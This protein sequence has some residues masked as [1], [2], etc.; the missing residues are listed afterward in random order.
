MKAK[1]TSLYLFLV[2]ISVCISTP[3]IADPP[4]PYAVA[5]YI[6]SS[7]TIQASLGTLFLV[8][9]TNI[10]QFVQDETSVPVPGQ[11]GRYSVVINGS[12]GD[13]LYTQA[14]NATHYGRTDFVLIGIMEGINVT[15]NL[16][17]VEQN[18]TIIDPLPNSAETINVTFN[19]TANIT[20]IGGAD[21]VN[22]NV[23]ISF[24]NPSVLDLDSGETAQHTI[25]SIT[26][27][28]TVNETWNVI[29]T[30][31]GSSNVTI[32]S[33]CENQTYFTYDNT[34]TLLNITIIGNYPKINTIS[35]ENIDLNPGTTKTVWCNGTAWDGDGFGDLYNATGVIYSGTSSPGAAQNNNNN[36]KDFD[37][38]TATFNTDGQF[39]CSFDVQFFAEADNWTCQVNITDQSGL[40]NTSTNES[41]L[42]ELLAIG[43]NETTI[44]F[45]FLAIGADSGTDDTIVVVQNLGNVDMDID[46]DTYDTSPGS[47]NAMNCTTGFIP[48]T[49]IRY[50]LTSSIDYSLKTFI[51]GIE[52]LIDNSFNLAKQTG[53]AETNPTTKNIYWGAGIPGSG[54][55]GSCSGKIFFGAVTDS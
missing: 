45:G 44:N 31:E 9:N 20:A 17:R 21:S 5:G 3:V 41:V 40:S 13:L 10:S 47:S 24:D 16:S 43:I 34:N 12:D 7:G 27:G 32:I 19:V 11:S 29:G 28:T 51:P 26:L 18:V 1:T 42:S 35:L 50:N 33:V 48:V 52:S 25:P 15:L 6:Y 30:S 23:T 38:A 22:C 39:A 4:T 53:P 8:N 36:Y 37:C 46:L 14:W 55:A 54:T 2:I 49:N